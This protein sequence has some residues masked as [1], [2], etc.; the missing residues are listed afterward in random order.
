MHPSS[1]NLGYASDYTCAPFLHMLVK[2]VNDSLAKR[3]VEPRHNCFSLPAVNLFRRVVV[4]VLSLTVMSASK[5]SRSNMWT[6][7]SRKQHNSSTDGYVENSNDYKDLR[8][9]I[10]GQNLFLSFM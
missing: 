1:R 8:T 10:E 4:G 5:L 7:S 2:L 6:S 9:H 3:M